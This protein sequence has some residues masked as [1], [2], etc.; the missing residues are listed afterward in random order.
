MQLIS[1]LIEIKDFFTKRILCFVG[2]LITCWLKQWEQ[3]PQR[4]KSNALYHPCSII[5]MHALKRQHK[6]RWPK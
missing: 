2:T 3:I 4:F 1:S 5:S 6:P